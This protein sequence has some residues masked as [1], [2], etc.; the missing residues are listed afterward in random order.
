MFPEPPETA[1]TFDDVLLV[2]S[3]SEDVL[4]K[5]DV[6]TRLAAGLDL[7]IPLLSAAM[8]TVTDSRMAIAMAQLGGIGVIHRNFPAEEQA[9][10]VGK[11]KR[12][13]S[14][15]VSS[16]ECVSPGMTVSEVLEVK[17]K[18]GFSGLPVVEDGLVVGIVT[19]RDLRF[20][21]RLDQP[22]SKVM[23]PRER[24][25]TVRPNVGLKTALKLMHEH[26]IERVIVEDARGRLRGLVTMKD[27]LRS[28]QHPTACKDASGSLRVAAAVGTGDADRTRRLVEAGADAIV[29]DSAHGHSS[30]VLAE[31]R[32]IKRSHP[33]TKVVGGNIATAE[34][35]VA[36]AEA[37]ADAVKVGVGPGSICTT[38]VVAGIGVPQLSAIMA[39]AGALRRRR[40]AAP[41][42]IADGGVRYS[43]DIAKAIAAGADCVMLGGVLAG[44]EEAPGETELF[45]GRVYKSYRG[46]GSISAMGRGSKG[47]YFQADS[48]DEKLVPEGVEGRVPYKGPVHEVIHQLTGGLR[49]AMGYTGNR[50]IAEM[51][52]NCRFVRIT[53]AG[54]RESHVHDVQITKEAPNYRVD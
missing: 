35:A 26:R 25:V 37:K 2:P 15:V 3:A 7:N 28:E 24:L 42:V 54:V 51:K 52:R 45:Q 33:R 41:T 12:Y 14:G 10:E 44:S 20:E 40:G 21:A 32:A 8:D 29:V 27:I 17:R 18:C 47:R 13:E 46:M 48:P 43:G 30:A 23:T 5:L 19:N 4:P 22:I 34:A 16:P 49:A 50:T 38:R 9:Q 53:Q 39:V 11:V 6:R 31:V 1:L 36:M